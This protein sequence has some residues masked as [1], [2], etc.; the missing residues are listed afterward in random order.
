MTGPRPCIALLALSLVVLPEVQAQPLTGWGVSVG[1]GALDFSY[2]GNV[3]GGLRYDYE[4]ATLVL[5]Y[6]S[7]GVTASAVVGTSKPRPIDLSGNVLLGLRALRAQELGIR[8]PLVLSLGH[9]R[10]LLDDAQR[11][12]AT[13]FGFGLGVQWVPPGSGL[14]LRANPIAS[15]VTSSLATGYGFG[16]GAELDAE[17]RVAEL[18]HDWELTVGYT[19]RYQDWN[20]QAARNALDEIDHY[21]DYTSLSHVAR[22][23]LRF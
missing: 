22:V 5:E 6:R 15:M 1:G 18:Q 17:L 11:W 13:R 9:F 2:V 10:S 14:A 3:P 4:G 19:F 21:F 20:I 16:L 7:S 12:D 23:G 8:V